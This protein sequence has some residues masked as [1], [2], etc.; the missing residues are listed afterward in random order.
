MNYTF[1]IFKRLQNGD[2]FWIAAVRGFA[3]AIARIDRLARI[4]PG[5]YLIYLQ[6]EGVIAER[7]TGRW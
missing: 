5:D 7:V 3:E 2:S 1:D 4:V 6:G